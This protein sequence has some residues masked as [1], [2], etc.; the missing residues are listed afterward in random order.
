MD[1]L[2]RLRIAL[3]ESGMRLLGPEPVVEA[4]PSLAGAGRWCRREREVGERSAEI[5]ARAADDDWRAPLRERSV[6]S[7]VCET[8]VLGDGAFAVERSDAD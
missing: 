4:L 8:L 7:L 3:G 6:D 1:G 2:R 5:E